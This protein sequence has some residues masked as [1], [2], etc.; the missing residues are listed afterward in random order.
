MRVVLAVFPHSAEPRINIISAPQPPT[1]TH[2]FFLGNGRRRRE[3]RACLFWMLFWQGGF[4]CR[5]WMTELPHKTWQLLTPTLGCVCLYL[6]VSYWC[7]HLAGLSCVF[8][9]RAQWPASPGCGSLLTSCCMLC[10]FAFTFYIVYI[11]APYVHAW[12]SVCTH[13]HASCDILLHS[14]KSPV[15]LA[16]P[17]CLS[18]MTS[19]NFRSSVSLSDTCVLSPPSLNATAT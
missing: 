1:M 14:S 18:L 12:I 6:F 4:S 9:C 11:Y 15:Q 13:L 7:L 19:R 10:L 2:S 16:P 8:A 3:V 5:A 17:P